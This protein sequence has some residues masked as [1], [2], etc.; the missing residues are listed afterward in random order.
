MG[1]FSVFWLFFRDSLHDIDVVLLTKSEN[2]IDVA[3]SPKVD[4]ILCA[5]FLQNENY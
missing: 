4:D 1:T 3:L 2:A 5:I